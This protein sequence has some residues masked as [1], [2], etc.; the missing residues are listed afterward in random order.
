VK[1]FQAKTENKN[2]GKKYQ[3]PEVLEQTVTGKS[4]N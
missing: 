4:I 2:V 1:K 3:F